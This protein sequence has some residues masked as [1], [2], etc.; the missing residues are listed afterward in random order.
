[1]YFLLLEWFK[2]EGVSELQGDTGGELLLALI[3]KFQEDWQSTS[4][5]ELS[6]RWVGKKTQDPN[7]RLPQTQKS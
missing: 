6:G 1:M 2:G 5:R 7:T 3:A 4:D